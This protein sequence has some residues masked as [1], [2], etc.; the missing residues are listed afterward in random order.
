M[1]DERLLLS[2][3]VQAQDAV[4]AMA[5]AGVEVVRI[6]ARWIEVSPGRGARR[7]PARLRP[8][9]PSLAPLRLGDARPGD[10]PHARGR[11]ARD[12][13]RHGPG[14]AVDEPQPAPAQPALQAEPGAVREVRPR[15]GDPLRRPRRP[16]PD[17]ERAEHRGLARAAADLRGAARLLPRLAAHLPRPRARRAAGDRARGP[18]RAGAARRARAARA[19]RDLDPQPGVAAAVPARAGVRE[20]ALQADAQR[21][22]AAA[23][24]PRAPTPSA[25]TRTASSSAPRTPTRIA[26]RPRS[27]TCRA[28]S[29][30]S[31]G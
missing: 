22:R 6:H 16:L 10:R 12:A 18:G 11:D 24:G 3:P 17:L 23:S 28:C 21:A 27:A 20:P 29:R 25:T 31:T 4:A 9:Q 5:A 14:A 15:R 1:E 13:E 30:C 8:R 26:T 2:E 7:R 19:P